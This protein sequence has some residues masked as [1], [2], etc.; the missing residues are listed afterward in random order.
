MKWWDGYEELMR[1]GGCEK[2]LN[3]C[4]KVDFLS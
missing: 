3:G 4:W 1:E 2:W